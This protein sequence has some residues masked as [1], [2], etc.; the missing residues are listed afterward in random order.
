[1]PLLAGVRHLH[2]EALLDQVVCCR[3]KPER[4]LLTLPYAFKLLVFILQRRVFTLDSFPDV[5]GNTLSSPSLPVAAEQFID[6][7]SHISITGI[8]P[9]GFSDC[10][11][12]TTFRFSS[13][14]V[15]SK[16]CFLPKLLWL[17][18]MIS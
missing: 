14:T 12:A 5:E 9:P 10:N 11:Y 18:L 3:S 4:L 13:S 6:V 1:M 7:N 15:P 8:I 17:Q 2:Q 16:F